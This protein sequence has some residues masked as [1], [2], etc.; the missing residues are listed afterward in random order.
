[1]QYV[2]SFLVSLIIFLAGIYAGIAYP[3]ILSF[4]WEQLYYL[5]RGF[6]VFIVIILFVSPVVYSFFYSGKRNGT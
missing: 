2:F 1:M 4:I 6:I 5:F 3:S